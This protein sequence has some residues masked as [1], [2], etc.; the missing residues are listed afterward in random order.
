MPV[1]IPFNDPN[2]CI[3][4]PMKVENYNKIM[5]FINTYI[6]LKEALANA[7]NTLKRG[8]KSVDRVASV[9][10]TETDSLKGNENE[11][12]QD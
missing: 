8:Q 7:D 4:Y 2:S 3:K 5:G 12:I 6:E 1:I 11:H 9:E 10:N